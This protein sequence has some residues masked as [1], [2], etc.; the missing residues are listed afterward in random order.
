MA[1]ALCLI[2]MYPAALLDPPLE[3]TAVIGNQRGMGNNIPHWL[4]DLPVPNLA[5][6]Y[7]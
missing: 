5:L 7:E 3:R 1:V 6:K 4:H 2:K